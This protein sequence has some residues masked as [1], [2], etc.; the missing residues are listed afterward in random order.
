MAGRDGLNLDLIIDRLLNLAVRGGL[1]SCITEQEIY[2]LCSATR[3]LFLA[4]PPLLEVGAPIKVAGDTHGQFAD[5]LRLFSRG[6]FPP[7]SN[8]LF[9]GDYVDRGKQSLETIILLFAY[10][11]K[12]PE[13]FFILR[14]NHEC[15][16]IKSV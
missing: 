16:A 4:Q 7:T 6:G 8:Y 11:L 5:L 2:R 15:A 14:G 13:N 3:E 12:Y 10:K 9:L 1:T